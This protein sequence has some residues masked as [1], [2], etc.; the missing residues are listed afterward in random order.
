MKTI[1]ITGCAGLLG[2]NFSRYL[3]DKKYKVIGIDNFFGGYKDF[4]PTNENF[5]FYE[6]NLETSDLNEI[7]N[8]VE[9][10]HL[11]PFWEAFILCVNEHRN[12]NPTMSESGASEYELYFN[13]MLKYHPEKIK[14]RELKWKNT[15]DISSIENEDYDYVSYHYYMR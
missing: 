14:I 10:A 5:K 3:L 13:Y 6:L 15:K 4:L 9:A 8:I 2:S 1:L 11:K 12:H 7:F